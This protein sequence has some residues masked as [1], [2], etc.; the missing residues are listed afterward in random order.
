MKIND[1]NIFATRLFIFEFNKDEI[2]PLIEE[3]SNKKTKIKN[4][5]KFYSSYT[6]VGKHY[7]DYGNSVRLIEYEKIML[8]I[9]NF[10]INQNKFFNLENYWSAIYYE[11]SLHSTHNHSNL[12]NK[13][14]PHNYSCVLYLTDNGGTTFFTSNSTSNDCEFYVKSKVGKLVIFPKSLLHN[15]VNKEKGERIIISSNISLYDA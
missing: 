9:G 2:Y 6:G 8:V 13:R 4:I 15:G 14:E 11:N 5:S 7:T 10:F 12:I 1:E 3:V